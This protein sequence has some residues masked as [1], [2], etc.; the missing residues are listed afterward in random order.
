MKISG[1]VISGKLKWEAG[2]HPDFSSIPMATDEAIFYSVYPKLKDLNVANSLS[3]NSLAED[4]EAYPLIV[5]ETYFITNRI[6]YHLGFQ[7]NNIKFSLDAN[8][9]FGGNWLKLLAEAIKNSNNI[10][11]S[12]IW[13][14]D[15]REE[16]LT[17]I[18]QNPLLSLGDPE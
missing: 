3:L 15:L 8:A 11:D 6:H 9:A 2:L 14:E 7:V 13:E 12:D 5:F 10:S 16:I 17:A 18:K 4:E 1:L